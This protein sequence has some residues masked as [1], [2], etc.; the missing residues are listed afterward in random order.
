MEEVY[1]RIAGHSY[2]LIETQ[3][4][5]DKMMMEHEMKRGRLEEKQMEMD[6]QMR[7]EVREFQ[8]KVMSMLARN[9]HSMSPPGAPSYPMHSTNVLMDMATMMQIPHKMACG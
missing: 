2:K 7:M 4:K 8:P 5:N 6:I 9:T 1:K 3:E